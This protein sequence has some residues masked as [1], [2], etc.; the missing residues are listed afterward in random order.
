MYQKIGQHGFFQR[1]FEGLYEAV[2]EAPYE[3]DGVGEEKRLVVRQLDAA[4]GSV[5]GGEEFVFGEYVAACEVVEKGAFT[6]VGVTDDSG[7]GDGEAFALLTAGTTLFADGFELA[8]GTIDPLAGDAAVDLD[9]FLA[10]TPGC[11]TATFTTTGTTALPVEVCPHPGEPW[12]GVFHAGEFYLESSFFCAGTHGEDIKDDLLAVD[13]TDV[14][15][16]FPGALLGGGEFVVENDAV[17][18][19][20]FGQRD[21]FGGF[22]GSGEVAGVDFSDFDE[23][24][25]DGADAESTHEFGQLL[26]EAGGFVVVCFVEI[27]ADKQRPLDHFW[28]FPDFEHGFTT[29]LLTGALGEHLSGEFGNAGGSRFLIVV[30]R[31][32]YRAATSTALIL[33]PILI[34]RAVAR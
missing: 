2:G 24:T 17:A 31:Y 6:C 11:T 21:E 23:L 5:E 20:V 30:F 28:F 29:I 8:F 34:N 10:L 13:H 33:E 7:V 15:V 3:T 26:E 16:F 19:L 25:V 1:G 9:L 22:S 32:R 27:D 4:G 18:L 14:P 12:Q